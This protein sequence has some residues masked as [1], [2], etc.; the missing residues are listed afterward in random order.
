MVLR[1]RTIVTTI[2]LL[3]CSGLANVSAQEDIRQAKFLS[4]T[5]TGPF[6]YNDVVN[7]VYES[8]FSQPVLYY[9]CR[10]SDGTA[11]R[12]NDLFCRLSATVLE[13]ESLLTMVTEKYKGRVSPYNSSQLVVLNATLG[14]PCWFNI[15][16]NGSVSTGPNSVNFIYNSTARSTPITI[17]LDPSSSLTSDTSTVATNSRTTG[18]STAAITTDA[19]STSSEGA[20][21]GLGATS[22][23]PALSESSGT[24]TTTGLSVGSQAGIGIGCGLLGVGIGVAITVILLRRHRKSIPP[25]ETDHVS[26]Q[27]E[28]P[29]QAKPEPPVE[30]PWTSETNFSHYSQPEHQDLVHMASQYQ[31]VTT[32]QTGSGNLKFQMPAFA[33]AALRSQEMDGTQPAQEMEGTQAA[34]EMDS[35]SRPWNSHLR[36][37]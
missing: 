28:Q 30:L 36:S 24:G 1:S 7:V 2:L 31:W 35:H 32:D 25:T 33:S 10:L 29:P 8:N 20:S 18:T 19:T 3:F 11:N 16:T 21:H 13:L 15:R 4:P 17:G 14:S 12:K 37:N 22:T 26:Q 9:F 27:F 6:Y 23:A 5:G 34:Q